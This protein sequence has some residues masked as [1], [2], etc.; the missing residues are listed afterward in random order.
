LLVGAGRAAR[1][2]ELV[3]MVCPRRKRAAWLGEN[4][5]TLVAQACFYPML[6]LARDRDSCKGVERV[7]LSAIEALC[8]MVLGDED[9]ARTC[10]RRHAFDQ[11]APVDT[12]ICSLL[13]A[14]RLEARPIEAKLRDALEAEARRERSGREGGGID[15]VL[16][17]RCWCAGEQG[18]GELVRFWSGLASK[19]A[20]EAERCLCA[21]WL[22]GQLDAGQETLAA[23]AEVR[24]CERFVRECLVVGADSEP[25]YFAVSAG[26]SFEEARE[27]GVRFAGEPLDTASL[28]LLRRV[29]MSVLSQRRQFEEEKSKARM[30]KGVPASAQAVGGGLDAPFPVEPK[31]SIPILTVHLFGH[32]E[33]A[34]GGTPLDSKRFNRRN[35]QMLLAL[36]TV[37]QGRELSRESIER[38]MWPQSSEEVAH[39][40]FYTV[41]S[42]LR[43]AL[44]LPDGSCPYLMRHQLG[45]R[46]E[47]RYVQSDV[48]RLSEICRELLFGAPNVEKW[49]ALFTEI[50]RDFSSEL[51]PAERK[52]RLIVQARHEYRT[53]LVDAL[54][55]AT[56]SIIEID[57]PRWGV[58]FARTAIA[59]D[60]TRED[61]YVAL[62]RAQ[63]AGNQRTAAMMTYLKCRRVLSDQLG[64]DPSPETTMLYE[65]LLDSE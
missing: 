18:F 20:G 39:K 8:R 37:N 46:L 27:R 31:R 19:G 43:H 25:D 54:V 51:M 42:N 34:I 21:S 58:W 7:R 65:S 38:A 62:M 41:W 61:A 1:A 48:E 57:N 14:A 17:A 16:L 36:L 26:L 5:Q 28:I 50:D 4:A 55:A 40:N 12:R 29:E 64:I 9:G 2:C 63:I 60:E 59:H 35:S 24:A 44:T 53:R 47:T 52:N 23:A 49:A 30:R 45:C 11:D 22:F 33:A 15:L 6:L 3:R 10:A 56:T 13:V 32:F